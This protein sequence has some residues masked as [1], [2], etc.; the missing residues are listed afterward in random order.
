MCI[1][2]RSIW[3]ITSVSVTLPYDAAYTSVTRR[4]RPRRPVYMHCQAPRRKVASI[5]RKSGDPG[6]SRLLKIIRLRLNSPIY[7][8]LQ[9]IQIA[10][11]SNTVRPSFYH[12]FIGSSREHALLI[13][14]ISSNITWPVVG[15]LTRP[16]GPSFHEGTRPLARSFHSTSR[17]RE[18]GQ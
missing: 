10:P 2:D 13:F 7:F 4:S 8:K 11:F 17:A 15:Q 16:T 12:I 14:R 5:A 3:R 9:T 18:S 1:R 6:P